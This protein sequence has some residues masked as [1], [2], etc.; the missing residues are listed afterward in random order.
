MITPSQWRLDFARH[1]NTK[2]C[3]FSGVQA[4]LVG[5]SVARGY[6]DD[7][8]DLELILYWKDAPDP[9]IKRTIITA[10]EAEYRYPTFDHGHESALLIHGFPVDLWHKTLSQEEATLKEVLDEYSINLDKSNILDTL[11]F[12][13]PLHGKENIDSW[14]A[15]VEQYPETLSISFLEHYLPHFHLRQLYFAV[16]RE[17]STAIYAMLSA[18][19]SSLFLILLAL[20]RSYFPTYKWLYKR[21]ADLPLVP[22]QLEARLKQMF[23]EP[24]IDAAVHLHSV[25]TETLALVEER[26]PKLDTTFAHYGLDQKPPKT[27][28]QNRSQ[29]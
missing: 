16:R 26:F 2:L 15:R 1:L 5:G 4:V 12:G 3:R 24:P 18:I 19:Q 13:I 7:Y 6:A 21:L 25:L 22:E 28:T 20:N 27:Y 9:E 23:R 14:K 29:I 8:S 10:L 17:N 11:R